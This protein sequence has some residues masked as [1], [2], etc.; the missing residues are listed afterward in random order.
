MTVSYHAEEEDEAFMATI[1]AA[2]KDLRRY[3]RQTLSQLPSD[4]LTQQ[5]HNV[6]R[7]LFSMPEY[8]RARRLSIYMSMA[9]GEVVTGLVV[10]DAFRR[11]KEVFIPYTYKE[12][13]AGSKQATSVM[14]MVALHSL[15]DYAQLKKNIWDIPSPSQESIV[16]RACCLREKTSDDES[17]TI[18]GKALDM[19]LV[20]G[21]AFD[22]LGGRLGHGKGFYDRF[23]DRY[24]D[25]YERSSDGPGTMPHLV[26]LALREQVL[27]E[28]QVVPTDSSDW[29]LDCLLVGDGRILRSPETTPS[30]SNTSSP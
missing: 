7:L 13:P 14:D 27:P 6:M 25:R 23:L 22:T 9:S 20:P 21:M 19:I 17:K 11:G 8:Q 4:S 18:H 2:K 16:S 15:D 3:M 5:S 29:Q 12:M 30:N 24:Q 26:G 1:R 10:R 28:G